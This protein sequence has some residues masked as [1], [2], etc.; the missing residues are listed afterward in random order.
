MKRIQTQ[1]LLKTIFHRE[2]CKYNRIITIH[3]ITIKMTIKSRK[4]MPKDP[5]TI[6]KSIDQHSHH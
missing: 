4:Q 6:F 1:Q 5:E 3:S 2:Y